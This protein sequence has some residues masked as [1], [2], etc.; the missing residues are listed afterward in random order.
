M[1]KAPVSQVGRVAFELDRFELVGG[2]CCE[3]QGRWS[4]VRGR[5]F[6]RPALTMIV[7]GQPT[8]LLADLAHKPWA[9]ED[10]E[11]WQAAFPCAL[12]GGDVLEAELTVAP[13]VTI[14]LPAPQGRKAARKRTRPVEPAPRTSSDSAALRSELAAVTR[15]LG[16]T[17]DEQQRLQGLL[18]RGEAENAQAA[19][20]MDHLLGDLSQVTDERAEARAALERLAA[21]HE[22]L[23]T[24]RD[25]IAAERGAARRERETVAGER[26][27]ALRARD[28]ALQ[29]SQAAA[30][31]RDRAVAERDAARAAHDRAVSERVAAI[32][33]QEGA[34]SERDDALAARAHALAERDAAVAAR[35][36]AVAERDAL[37]RTAERLQSELADLL[38]ARGAALV[39]RRAAQERPASRPFAGLLPGAI[40]LIVLLAIALVIVLRVV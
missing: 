11:P 8:R 22:S 23:Q 3:L 12:G 35:D 34:G 37:S 5:R 26:D 28:E 19:A 20:R 6:M 40:A 13:D 30:A 4:G 31:E 27:A 36:E 39:M 14:A 29:A 7:D 2:T 24:E 10:G 15:E 33:A 17:R 16:E 32:A 1:S 18:Q 38:S 9:A 25:Q 21:E